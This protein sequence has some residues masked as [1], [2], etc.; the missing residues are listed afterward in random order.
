MFTIPQQLGCKQA[1][2]GLYS[3]GVS[4]Y[5]LWRCNHQTWNGGWVV[6]NMFQ[7]MLV[8]SV[9]QKNRNLEMGPYLMKNPSKMTRHDTSKESKVSCQVNRI[10]V[11]LSR[12][13]R[14]S[15]CPKWMFCHRL[16]SQSPFCW[17]SLRLFII[18]Y[19]FWLFDVAVE[20]HHF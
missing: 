10:T 19:T 7:V 12:S 2:L 18:A 4:R 14:D 1:T 8:S 15:F 13:P 16:L 20:N 5:G 3:C 6:V 9:E 11:W 17:L